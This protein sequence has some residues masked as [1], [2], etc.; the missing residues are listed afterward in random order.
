MVYGSL[1]RVT[2]R[3]AADRPVEVSPRCAQVRA[4]DSHRGGWGGR[5]GGARRRNG[6][7]PRGGMGMQRAAGRQAVGAA[8][9][10]PPRSSRPGAGGGGDHSDGR[11]DPCNFPMPGI[12]ER[13]L[14]ARATNV[15]G[16]L[17][18]CISLSICVCI[19]TC[20][21]VFSYIYM[22]MY[23]CAFTPMCVCICTHV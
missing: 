22:R 15:G 9:C 4:G 20:V 6:T 23:L 8:R 11:G 19:C 14:A 16:F 17:C 5:T 12:G 10:S 7:G 21:C 2:K 1:S 18:I 3:S 13:L